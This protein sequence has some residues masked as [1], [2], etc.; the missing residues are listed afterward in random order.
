MLFKKIVG[1]I[2]I[3]FILAGLGWT[4]SQILVSSMVV[5]VGD[6][7]EFNDKLMR[8]INKVISDKNVLLVLHSKCKYCKKVI[9]DFESDWSSQEKT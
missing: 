5:K 8:E 1:I 6:K 3:F 9:N 4:L 2:F 7:L